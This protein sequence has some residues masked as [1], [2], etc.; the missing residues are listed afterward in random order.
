MVRQRAGSLRSVRAPGS[1]GLRR[2][3][4]LALLVILLVCVLLAAVAGGWTLYASVRDEMDRQLGKRLLSIATTAS[5]AIGADRFQEIVAQ[6][7]ASSE[8]GRIRAELQA[9]ALANDLDN[10]T[11]VDINR[12]PVLDLGSARSASLRK[13]P[14]SGSRWKTLRNVVARTGGLGK[15]RE[16]STAASPS[17]GDSSGAAAN[18]PEGGMAAPAPDPLLALQPEL[19]TTL[20]SGEPR[21]TRLVEIEGLSGEYL[22]T[23]Y[24]AVEDSSGDILGA[25]AVEGGSD[26]FSVLP[27]MRR[28][29][30]W[31]GALA[32]TAVLVLGFL[33]FRVLRSFLRYEDSLRRAAALAAIGQ[34]SAIVAHEIRNPL[35]IIRS[36]SERV[37]SK[38]QAGR[39]PAEVLEW[40]E[41]IP[42]EVDRLD[43]IL[44]SYLSLARPDQEASG[45]CVPAAV[46]EETIRL[47]EPELTKKGIRIE[48][49]MEDGSAPIRMGSRSLKQ[50]L[51]NLMLNSSQAMEQAGGVLSLRLRRSEPW[52][53]L[54]VE[55]TGTGMTE[56]QRQRALEP[57]FTTRATGSGLGLTL[58]HSL[59]QA[60]G[61]SLAIRSA[62]GQGTRVTIQLPGDRP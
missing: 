39:D 57:F 40:F 62:P 19:V 6:G 51:L 60:R 15:A 7:P 2:S 34:I 59:V 49:E 28:K 37:R 43:G 18:G 25:I 48:T 42:A 29:I 58:V 53:I 10:I 12:E 32:L 3:R 41:A 4:Y 8:Y 21:A 56:A 24:A 20:L 16:D 44:S 55:D 31:A 5:Q 61:G 38:I 1:P 9:T 35:A 14:R 52:V 11:L 33:I 45:S 23:G 47:L 22:K 26:F 17:G 30:L 13:A 36:R 46:I 27:G 54:E 50:I